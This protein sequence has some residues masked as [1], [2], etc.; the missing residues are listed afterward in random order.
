MGGLGG[1]GLGRG[2]PLLQR[3]EGVAGLIGAS[4]LAK[5][6]SRSEH[7]VRLERSYSVDSVNRRPSDTQTSP[8]RELDPQIS[9]DWGGAD[10]SLSRL[11]EE[12]LECR[13]RTGQSHKEDHLLTKVIC[14]YGGMASHPPSSSC[15]RRRNQPICLPDQLN[16][17][18]LQ[19]RSRR[20]A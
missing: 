6:E 1:V 2:I 20:H 5:R 9:G 8:P 13:T 14:G 12:R 18:S 7:C 16:P 15:N 11:G 3:R 10:T 19:P 17:L 4:V